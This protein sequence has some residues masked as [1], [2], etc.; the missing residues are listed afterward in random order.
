MIPSVFVSVAQ[1]FLDSLGFG[2]EIIFPQADIIVFS[3]V[4]PKVKFSTLYGLAEFVCIRQFDL[5][6]EI[7][8]PW[9]NPHERIRSTILFE[10]DGASTVF[11][12]QFRIEFTRALQH[13]I[14]QS[15]RLP[16]FPLLPIGP[17]G[18]RCLGVFIIVN[19]PAF[20]FVHHPGEHQGDGVADPECPHLEGDQRQRA[21]EERNHVEEADRN[22]FGH[23]HCDVLILWIAF[24]LDI[25]VLNGPDDVGLVCCPKL[26]FHLVP[27]IGL[28]ILEEQIE[29]PGTRL[30][31]F[32]IPQLQIA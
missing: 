17:G 26:N 9:R 24:F 12:L 21:V 2:F 13:P 28:G 14:G 31:P 5:Q 7:L 23:D 8:L 22:I 10:Y 20:Q 6:E 11:R 19:K 1:E 15:E 27:P 30:S 29:P 4:L 3:P 16:R 32:P 25:P 18:W